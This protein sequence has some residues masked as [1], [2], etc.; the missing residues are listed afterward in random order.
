M[1]QIQTLKEKQRDS[2]DGYAPATADVLLRVNMEISNKIKDMDAED[3]SELLLV[4]DKTKPTLED[5]LVA[6]SQR[7]KKNRLRKI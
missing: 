3:I 1:A 6:E 2:I 4:F 7:K 5:L